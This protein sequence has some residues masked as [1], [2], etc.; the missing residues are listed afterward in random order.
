M[1]PQN[2]PELLGIY[3][4]LEQL[5]TPNFANDMD[6]VSVTKGLATKDPKT[7][8]D[9]HEKTTSAV[10]HGSSTFPVASPEP[11]PKPILLAPAVANGKPTQRIDIYRYC[12]PG[13]PEDANMFTYLWAI[14]GYHG[15]TSVWQNPT[16]Q[17]QEF[18]SRINVHAMMMETREMGGYDM[19]DR[20]PSLWN[21]L[22]FRLG[23]LGSRDQDDKRAKDAINVVQRVNKEWLRP[24]EEYCKD[25]PTVP[26]SDKDTLIA[27]LDRNLQN[28][29]RVPVPIARSTGPNVPFNV[30][31]P[32][33]SLDPITPGM[34]SYV[35]FRLHGY[36][37]PG[38]PTDPA[39]CF[40]MMKLWCLSSDPNRP[41]KAPPL[42]RPLPD[43][44]GR[45]GYVNY[46]NMTMEIN[47]LGGPN[48]LLHL[49]GAWNKL[50]FRLRLTER[51]DQND[52]YSSQVAMLL[53]RYFRD[54][55][56]HFGIFCDQWPDVESEK[57]K[58]LIGLLLRDCGSKKLGKQPD[59]LHVDTR[60]VRVSRMWTLEMGGR[61]GPLPAW[62]GV[63]PI[64][65]ILHM[66]LLIE[67]YGG[68]EGIKRVPELWIEMAFQL[69]L[70][71]RWERG[72]DRM[73]FLLE[74][75]KYVYH[76]R[77]VPFEAFCHK[78][79]KITQD[80]KA[81]HVTKLIKMLKDVRSEIPPP[82]SPSTPETF[83]ADL[84]A[85]AVSLERKLKGFHPDKSF[86]QRIQ[87]VQMLLPGQ[88]RQY[89]I[90]ERTIKICQQLSE[91]NLKVMA[92]VL[93]GAASSS[94]RTQINTARMVREPLSK[95]PEMLPAAS[96]EV[97]S[98]SLWPEIIVQAA[99]R[100]LQEIMKRI[101]ESSKYR[102]PFQSDKNIEWSIGA[103]DQ[104]HIQVPESEQA[105]VK[106]IVHD[107]YLVALEFYHYAIFHIMIDA[108]AP[109][110]EFVMRQACLVLE[111]YFFSHA[112]S[113]TFIVDYQ[114]A[115]FARRILR[116][117]VKRIKH[118]YSL[119][120]AEQ[121]S[122]ER[123]VS[124]I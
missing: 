120:A 93:A 118:S 48:E 66:H 87:E 49:P 40:Y 17:S 45:A 86:E 67:G 52:V 39:T 113:P 57:K 53:R 116:D 76:E 65:S 2:I 24:F 105:R 103:S 20:N 111:Q 123:T 75:L 108:R 38:I 16:R 71:A 78:W 18:V 29:K 61:L 9:A 22:A 30:H 91:G 35:V 114:D 31:W 64:V 107:T 21:E 58:S 55:L 11:N 44:S 79:P 88:A 15:K 68:I 8:S 27:T 117:Q 51:E 74:T 81:N 83:Y 10:P 100:C 36:K 26:P 84:L 43:A 5:S 19:L 46:F 47:N 102:S 32:P 63:R 95:T 25:W 3:E 12:H 56:V 89:G 97:A 106:Q 99:Q 119:R 42:P 72:S 110:T 98:S 37:G 96:T 115:Q 92:A 13:A 60:S 104:P 82:P 80:E 121:K 94:K 112:G 34:E 50:A 41:E 73:R 90:D 54:Y 33:D 109:W 77:L 124:S 14:R 1:T 85:V 62:K 101:N 4:Q 70:A 7:E 23:L 59:Q 69:K 28:L 6:L 122:Q